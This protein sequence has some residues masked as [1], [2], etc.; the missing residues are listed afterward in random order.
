[1]YIQIFLRVLA[2]MP[3]EH[4]TMLDITMQE[5]ADR[6]TMVHIIKA[7]VPTTTDVM[8]AEDLEEAE[9]LQEQ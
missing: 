9:E 6:G 1:M 8:V 4:H 7:V 5:Q 2:P 3:E